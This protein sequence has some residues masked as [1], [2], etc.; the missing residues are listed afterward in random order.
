M[1]KP[2]LLFNEQNRIFFELSPGK[3]GKDGQ[4]TI[5]KGQKGDT[6]LFYAMK[7]L[8][9]TAQIRSEH[10]R[11]CSQRRK[12]ISAGGTDF[13]ST[14]EY[15]QA[16]AK[17]NEVFL[18]LKGH[19]P[20][21]AVHD[22]LRDTLKQGIAEVP[23]EYLTP[24]MLEEAMAQITLVLAEQKPWYQL[25]HLD[26]AAAQLMTSG[27]GLKEVPCA[28]FATAQRLIQTLQKRGPLMIIGRFGKHFYADHN[29]IKFTDTVGTRALYGWAKGTPTSEG[30]EIVHAIVLVGAEV[31]GEKRYVYWID[32]ENPNDPA[33]P[34]SQRIYVSSFETI[35]T[36]MITVAGLPIDQMSPQARAVIAGALYN[37]AFAP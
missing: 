18:K 21:K 2:I 25:E 36:R 37:P 15:Y 9:T 24:T 35:V 12:M 29:P 31:K 22:F 4:V 13:S 11:A 34:E 17:A 7:R 10:G 3:I 5:Q 32:P 30:T 20:K 14:Q 8:L 19:D 23:A 6:C 33:D 16:R 28:D 1:T 26:G 27:H